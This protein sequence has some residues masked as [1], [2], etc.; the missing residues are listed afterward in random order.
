LTT[1]EMKAE[2]LKVLVWWCSF[3]LGYKHAIITIS[4]LRHD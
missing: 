3:C 2:A 1:A 4:Q